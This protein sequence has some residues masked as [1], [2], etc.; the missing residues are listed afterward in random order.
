M[1]AKE[2]QIFGNPPNNLIGRQADGDDTLDEVHD[3]A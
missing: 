3:I 1:E 2:G